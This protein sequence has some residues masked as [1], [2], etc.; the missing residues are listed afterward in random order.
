MSRISD[1]RPLFTLAIPGTHQSA[2]LI[3][4]PFTNCQTLSIM[5]QL[6]YG[7]RFFDLRVRHR[8]NKFL[9]YH[10]V[11]DQRMS[12]DAVLSS[13][14]EFL[15]VHTKEVLIVS[16]KSDTGGKGNS[17]TF[18]ETFLDYEERY[19]HISYRES[20][21]P[22]LHEARGRIVWLNRFDHNITFGIKRKSKDCLQDN[23]LWVNDRYYLGQYIDRAKRL[24]QKWSLVL[25]SMN[26]YYDLEMGTL[27]LNFASGYLK[28]GDIP[29]IREVSSYVNDRIR[30]EFE[31]RRRPNIL[32]VL[33][34]DHISRTLSYTIL[35]GNYGFEDEFF[36][37]KPPGVYL[38]RVNFFEG[39][40]IYLSHNQR[41]S[42]LKSV[43][44]NDQIHS[45]LI[46]GKS[47]QVRLFYEAG[48]GGTS[49]TLDTSATDLKS[50]GFDI[51]ASSV[52]VTENQPG[53]YL[54]EHSNFRAGK[55][56]YHQ[57]AHE[58]NGSG[59]NRMKI[60]SVRIVGFYKV[61][62]FDG[63]DFRG[64]NFSLTKSMSFLY[65]FNDRASSYQ[66]IPPRNRP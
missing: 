25:E 55:I 24:R 57:L 46:V 44:M 35:K 50:L 32:G 63:T 14:A 11:I 43:G 66:I 65:P 36:W 61:I 10:G 42:N 1:Y 15:K 4:N 39:P 21:V 33:I 9:M 37:K 13:M 29:M 48:F 64:Q 16:V 60:S 54:Y 41:I 34:T 27:I 17:R 5:D 20:G 28:F 49:I 22:Y 6:L 40:S 59:L 45:V 12:F 38:Y 51:K 31:L 58:E 47:Y 56:R 18:E 19:K 26:K 62:L 7:V 30:W 8:S 52:T 23:C 2:S 53:V 3:P